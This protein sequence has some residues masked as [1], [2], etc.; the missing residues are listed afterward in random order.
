MLDELLALY[1]TVDNVD[2]WIAGL[3]EDLV[4]D[5]RVGPTFQCLLIEQF[6]RFRRGDR[7]WFENESTFRPRFKPFRVTSF[8]VILL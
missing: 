2:L 5:G 8:Y 6:A 1:G 4:G 7:F 3:L